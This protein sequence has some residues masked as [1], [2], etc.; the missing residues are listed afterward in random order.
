[1]AVHM[2][3][4]WCFVFQLLAVVAACAWIASAHEGNW[5]WHVC[6]LAIVAQTTIVLVNATMR[7]DLIVRGRGGTA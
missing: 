2:I 4:P 5:P 1:M 7:Y 3:N 6:W